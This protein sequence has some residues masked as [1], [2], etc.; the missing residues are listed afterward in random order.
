MNSKFLLP[1]ILVVLALVAILIIP[2]F[3]DLDPPEPRMA[4]PPGRAT[5]PAPVRLTEPSSPVVPPPAQPSA[6]P[7]PIAGETGAAM[8]V[9]QAL[10]ANTADDEEASIA[11]FT[12]IEEATVTYS[13]EGL[14]VL[15]PLLRHRDPEIR[16]AAIDGLVNLG[17]TSGAKVLREAARR[18]SDAAEARKMIQAAEFL[19]LPVYVPTSQ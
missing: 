1:I 2:I 6:A 9:D 5:A 16:A 15:G 4:E 17:Q 13:D 3:L 18:V 8:S 12:M 10:S 19:E 7:D 11:V 14:T